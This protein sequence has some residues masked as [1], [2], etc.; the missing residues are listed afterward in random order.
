MIGLQQ[1]ER[2][3]RAV[4]SRKYTDSGFRQESRNARKAGEKTVRVA[5]DGDEK[6]T[7][8]QAE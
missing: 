1:E 8:I 4:D 5:A 3:A 2:L 6:G 7:Q